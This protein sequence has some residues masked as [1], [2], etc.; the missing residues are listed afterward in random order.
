MPAPNAEKNIF[1]YACLRSRQFEFDLAKHITSDHT[2][3]A[4]VAVLF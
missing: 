3:A 4:R 1:T 2:S